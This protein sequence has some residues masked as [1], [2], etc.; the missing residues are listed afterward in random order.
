VEAKR[1][2]DRTA[3]ASAA[4]ASVANARAAKAAAA[5]TSEFTVTGNRAREVSAPLPAHVDIPLDT[6]SQAIR[7]TTAVRQQPGTAAAHSVDLDPQRWLENIRQLRKEGKSTEADR[8]WER[9]RAAFP[10]YAVADD[11]AARKK[12]QQEAD[13]G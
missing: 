4:N 8:E 13:G 12:E 5:E 6:P 3:A 9:F 1:A 10:D 11:D 7:Q 2:E